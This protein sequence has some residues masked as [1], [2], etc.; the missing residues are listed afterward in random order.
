MRYLP[1]L[2]FIEAVDG[3]DVSASSVRE[4][5]DKKTHT[6]IFSYDNK[7]TSECSAEEV[8]DLMVEYWEILR[9]EES[10]IYVN[11]PGLALMYLI[12]MPVHLT[13]YETLRVLISGVGNDW[14]NMIFQKIKKASNHREFC[15]LR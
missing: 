2:K 10:S 12:N 11:I 3:P 7:Y 6:C 4:V 13:I 5:L 15:D 8:T 9:H 1:D 14:N